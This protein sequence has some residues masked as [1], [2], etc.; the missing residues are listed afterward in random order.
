MRL[1]TFDFHLPEEL[2]ATRPARPRD[3]A[4]LLVVRG[5]DGALEDRVVRDLPDLLKAGDVMVANASRVIRAA[6]SGV[7][8]ARDAA[9]ADVPVEL[10]LHRQISSDTWDAFARPAR[11]LRPGD[12]IAF[13]KGLSAAIESKHDDGSVRLRFPLSGEAL[14]QA[15]DRAGAPPL[16]PYIVS[17]RSADDADAS[18]YQTMF[19]REAG[20]VAAPTAGLH[21]TPELLRALDAAGVSVEEVVLHVSAGTFLP[22]KVDD[23]SR[24]QM[25]SEFAQLSAEVAQRIRNARRMGGRCIPIGTTALRTLESAAASGEPQAFA[26]ET[27]IFISPGYQFR[28]TDGLMTNFHL[29]RSTLFILVCALMGVEV[30]KR[31]YAHAVKHGYRFYSY[32]DACLLLPNG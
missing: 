2:I 3:S 9:G 7:R 26:A 15:I 12:R 21:F 32:G 29:P 1:D 4:R 30:M 22:V 11:R 24:H 25:H 28:A 16:P 5:P 20:S 10:N 18:D 13:S 8:P 19:A 27:Q 17:K 6:L 31:A 14:A 23:V